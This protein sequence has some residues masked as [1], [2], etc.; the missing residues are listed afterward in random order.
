MISEPI[1]EEQ[2]E[3]EEDSPLPRNTAERIGKGVRKTDY[4]LPDDANEE[5]ADSIN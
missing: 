2:S 5:L 3:G 1:K 4:S